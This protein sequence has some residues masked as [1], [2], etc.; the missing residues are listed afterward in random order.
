M[1]TSGLGTGIG[2]TLSDGVAADIEE[3]ISI[4][5]RGQAC[6]VIDIS[7][8]GSSQTVGS[9]DDAGT[10]TFAE[11]LPGL[12]SGGEIVLV[13]R[14]SSLRGGAAVLS[15]NILRRDFNGKHI[16][17]WTITIPGA[18]ATSATWSCYGYISKLG[19]I[20]Q[21]RGST[22]Q[23]ISIKCTGKSTYTEAT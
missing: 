20:I 18:G 23:Q 11:F 13:L 9:G 6:S 21:Y 12:L 3:V 2:I 10:Y 8:A 19:T 17:E 16:R 22:T 14:Y 15:T 7:S 5:V 1:A 4:G